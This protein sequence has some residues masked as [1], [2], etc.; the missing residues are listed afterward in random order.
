VGGPGRQL[1]CLPARLRAAGLT[2]EPVETLMVAEI[3][4]LEPP[5][6]EPAGVR[7]VDVDDPSG[8]AVLRAIHDEVFGPGTT[9]PWV[10][11]A[12]RTALVQR[13]RPIQAV[14][15]GAGA[16][17]VAVSAGRVE[18]RD[19]T[20][21]AG[22]WGFPNGAAAECS[23]RWWVTA[24]SWPGTA[25]SATARWTPRPRA[26]R[27]WSGWASTPSLRPRPGCS[28]AEHAD[29][30]DDRGQEGPPPAADGCRTDAR[31]RLARNVS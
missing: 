11:E 22:L 21:F 14:L 29:L 25:A 28:S 10:L 13:P 2:P 5:V 9:H 18:F 15:A 26:G 8:V 24:P 7:M 31:R 19:G 23:G 3:A 1:A 20:D 4:D 17:D 12:V 30:P 27:S 6:A 16:G